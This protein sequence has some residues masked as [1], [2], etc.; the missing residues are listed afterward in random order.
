MAVLMRVGFGVGALAAIVASIG[1]TQAHARPCADNTEVL[2]RGVSYI[3]YTGDGPYEA[4]NLSCRK[5]RRIAKEAIR[6]KR[7]SG[8]RCRQQRRPNG[9][10][11][12]CVRGG[13]YTNDYGHTQWRYLIGWYPYVAH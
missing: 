6:G 10:S 13:T 12:R 5:A 3:V 2:V 4:A 7:V 1:A 8:W 11:G 9:F